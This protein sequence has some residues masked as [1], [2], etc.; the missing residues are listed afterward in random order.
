MQQ[1]WLEVA[2][3]RPHFHDLVTTISNT[4][5]SI[6]GYLGLQRRVSL[7]KSVKHDY[8]RS[9]RT[10]RRISEMPILKEKEEEEQLEGIEGAE[11]GAQSGG[12]EEEKEPSTKTIR[13]E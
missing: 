7:I 3:K 8:L 1:C 13:V 5:E 11:K 10:K 6:A 9:P 4:L 2:G 12:G